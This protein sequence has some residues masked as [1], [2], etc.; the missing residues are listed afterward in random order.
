MSG[1]KPD[2]AV[3]DETSDIP[4]LDG[5]GEYDGATQDLFEMQTADNYIA[6]DDFD[7]DT[8]DE[9]EDD[10][11]KDQEELN[12][13]KQSLSKSGYNTEELDYE[14][15][16][17]LQS[18]EEAIKDEQYM[19]GFT[20]AFH[21]YFE[22][23]R[24]SL[25]VSK[26]TLAS[27]ATTRSFAS[28]MTLDIAASPFDEA[29]TGIIVQ[30]VRRLLDSIPIEKYRDE[31]TVNAVIGALLDLGEDVFSRLDVSKLYTFLPGLIE[32]AISRVERFCVGLKS[33]EIRRQKSSDFLLEDERHHND[34][35]TADL[36][37]IKRVN[38]ISSDHYQCFCENCQKFFD[39]KQHFVSYLIY[40]TEKST[41]NY[42][43][44]SGN[45]KYVANIFPQVE[46]CPE[47]NQ[48]YVLYLGEYLTYANLIQSELNSVLGDISTYLY[49][50]STGTAFTRI[51]PPVSVLEKVAPYLINSTGMK[52]PVDTNEK[53]II[54][55]E[56]SMNSV[57]YANAIQS[58]YSMLSGIEGI[59]V[60]SAAA[61]VTNLFDDTDFDFSDDTEFSGLNNSNEL[62]YKYAAGYISTALSRDYIELHNRALCSIVAKIEE[63]DLVS[64]I[65][66]CSSIWY[67]QNILKLLE[68]VKNEASLTPELRN[69]L[70][71]V[72]QLM[73]KE[74]ISFT[75]DG[76][77]EYR[78]KIREKLSTM[79]ETRDTI[80]QHFYSSEDA[81]SR[82]SIGNHRQL[83]VCNLF[84]YCS[85]AKE[86][87]F[88]DR[89]ADRMIIQEL[90]E[91]FYDHLIKNGAFNSKTRL[92]LCSDD[93]ELRDLM[94]SFLDKLDVIGFLP[95]DYSESIKSRASHVSL[96]CITNLSEMA[97]HFK[98]E[99]YYKFIKCAR[100]LIAP[101]SLV[102]DRLNQQLRQLKLQAD[103]VNIAAD[104]SQEEYFLQDF[105]VDELHS[106]TA[107]CRR[108]LQ[109]IR[110]GRFVPK[111]LTEESLVDYLRRYSK[112]IHDNVF[113]TEE[114]YDYSEK[115]KE[116]EKYYIDILLC[117][118]I[119]QA[120]C[121]NYAVSAMT[122]DIIEG[123]VKYSDRYSMIDALHLNE[124]VYNQCMQNV[125]DVSKDKMVADGF[126]E[127]YRVVTE[128]YTTIA[129]N[130]FEP[131][132]VGLTSMHTSINRPIA[133]L[134]SELDIN[135]LIN[136]LV[137]ADAATIIK[138]E[139]KTDP[140]VEDTLDTVDTR[141]IIE[142]VTNEIEFILG[143]TI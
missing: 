74:G 13:L 116:F 79:R 135:R 117:D 7:F 38:K 109:G 62:E 110:F 9:H 125:N 143:R 90:S 114:C 29:D 95:I 63:S 65:I 124:I 69:A 67:W 105:S 88:W 36:K 140:T 107:E 50:I 137:T 22:N 19:T 129:K 35:L 21:G 101:E 89:I 113:D 17:T 61:T 106:A 120:T 141:G 55:Q 49:S 6:L 11:S 39:V 142:E 64:S 70:T 138:L 16:L 18:R 118:V 51:E 121:V 130:F 26:A 8:D 84:S 86:Y 4:L 134:Q 40:V 93:N 133:A 5:A 37:I 122:R 14:Q 76:I 2:A 112:A 41:D 43:T 98:N 82:L 42:Q 66:D 128:N 47:C 24:V 12:I 83:P 99:N 104:V 80:M 23:L 123:F 132:N 46:V 25:A 127:Y 45:S 139:K 131:Y 56:T 15:L 28:Q 77:M 60:D 68:E 27:K 44:F 100:N 81:L 10:L 58:F 92:K 91:E 30:V 3:L 103:S 75:L 54:T 108:L 33:H 59:Q 94:N 34:L 97:Y 71:D 78:N 102:S 136:Q 87:V 85:N 126:E 72:R 32:S 119:G 57:E 52:L 31:L 111:R 115:F 73:K 53:V 1:D 96:H 20:D 48:G